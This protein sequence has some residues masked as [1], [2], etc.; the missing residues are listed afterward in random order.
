MSLNHL[1]IHSLPPALSTMLR[2]CMPK[3]TLLREEAL[4]H[5]SIPN[6]N[7]T[8]ATNSYQVKVN[9]GSC[10]IFNQCFLTAST[11]YTLKYNLSVDPKSSTYGDT[12]EFFLVYNYDR[13]ACATLG[14]LCPVSLFCGVTYH[15]TQN[16]FNFTPADAG[17]Y[18]LVA[19]NTYN[20]DDLYLDANVLYQYRN[21][22]SPTPTIIQPH[23]P[24]ADDENGNSHEW[25]YVV[26][27][28]LAAVS[29]ALVFVLVATVVI[30]KKKQE[31]A[32]ISAA[33]SAPEN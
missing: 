9:A 33:F 22:P 31:E 21:S 12:L 19:R 18:Y 10:V 32:K 8:C 20:W 2:N 15:M 3:Y 26:I 5:H 29:L 7:D 6:Q 27:I 24:P 30:Y 23:P 1:L 11:Q 17:T 14:T 25:T 28:V 16:S 4:Y 13:N